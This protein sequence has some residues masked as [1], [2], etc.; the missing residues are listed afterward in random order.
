VHCPEFP[1]HL[2][3]RDREGA[4]KK[5]AFF[6]N[7][8]DDGK[9]MLSTRLVLQPGTLKKQRMENLRH[10][11]IKHGRCRHQFPPIRSRLVQFPLERASI[12][13]LDHFV[14]PFLWHESSLGLEF[15]LTVKVMDVEIQR[16]REGYFDCSDADASLSMR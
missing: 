16:R 7:L 3:S 10:Q 15:F 1:K 9:S 6:R 11:R 2:Q 4:V 14:F 13:G 8:L 5:N 12:F